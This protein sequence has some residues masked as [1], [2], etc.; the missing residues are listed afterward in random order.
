[1]NP[2]IYTHNDLSHEDTIKFGSVIGIMRGAQLS[3]AEVEQL[4]SET[5]T[6]FRY[7]APS[8]IKDG[9]IDEDLPYLTSIDKQL[10]RFCLKPNDII[11][12][13]IGA[14]F[15]VA[16]VRP[17]EGQKILANGN[18]Y[19]IRMKEENKKDVDP[20]Y[21]K[22]FLESCTGQ[23]VLKRISGGSL[24][25]NVSA[26]AIKNMD[27]SLPNM[28]QQKEIAARY[29]TTADEVVRLRRQLKTALEELGDILPPDD[30]ER[31]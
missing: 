1:M 5:E 13:K 2:K 11:L 25:P 4:H 21:V 29:L 22:V 26:E 30:C 9:M 28:P 20:C 6:E 15:K 3:S 8:G 31:M 7:L 27:I 10:E 16:L 24:M 14:P 12:S 19:I 23:K 17:S 18:L